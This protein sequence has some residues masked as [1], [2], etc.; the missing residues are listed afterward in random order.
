[1]HVYEI[2]CYVIKTALEGI[3][4]YVHFTQF[5]ILCVNISYPALETAVI[6]GT[7]YTFLHCQRG[8]DP[9]KF[10]QWQQIK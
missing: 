2:T 6:Q 4:Y 1:M 9:F 10:T 5:C 8:Q 3:Q 7:L